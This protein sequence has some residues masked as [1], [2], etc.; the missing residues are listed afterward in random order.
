MPRASNT[1]GRA[2][3]N[4]ILTGV[5]AAA[6][7]VSFCAPA[8]AVDDDTKAEI[9]LL[10]EQLRRLEKKLEAQAQAQKETQREVATVAQAKGV[11]AGPGNLLPNTKDDGSW[12]PNTLRYK[13]VTITPGGFFE[14]VG[15]HR[16][17]YIG[18]DV[19]TPFALI[20]YSNS[21]TAHQDETRFSARRSR[22]ILQTDADLDDITHARMYLATDFLSDPQTGTFTQSQSW[23]LRWRELYTK[24]DRQDFGADYASHFSLGQMY[25]LASLNSRGTTPD[26]FLTPPVIDDQYMPGYTWARQVGVRWSQNFTKDFQVA[27]GAEQSYTSANVVPGLAFNGTIA[28]VPWN[29]VSGYALTTGV[30][31]Y[32]PGTYLQTPI[33]GSLYY[34]GNNISFSH[35]PDLITK[36]AWDPDFYGHSVHIEGG[37]MLR[38]FDDRTYGGNHGVWGGGGFASV[39]VQVIPKWLDFQASGFSGNGI[40]RYGASDQS[41]PDVAFNWTGGL[42]PIHERQVMIGLTAHPTPATDV[43]VFAGG[44]FAAPTWGDFKYPKGIPWITPN[45]YA[46]GYGNPAFVNTGCNFEGAVGGATI[47]LS[48]TAATLGPAGACVGQTKDVRQITTGMWH[49]FYDGPAGKIR[50]GLQYSYTIRDSFQGVGGAFKGTENT[51]FTSFRYYPFN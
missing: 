12:W 29:P 5:S 42:V 44:E 2:G 7:L 49:N 39:V 10:K 38:Q 25:T 4:R 26:T 36:A 17:H 20:P 11:P 40:S 48:T 16:D 21:P 27:F 24:I 9:R 32:I 30:G 3:L 37:G 50:V 22:F 28:P 19:A 47:S 1:N 8:L 18:A 41:I 13:A 35:I 14:L 46:F 31:G 51:I 43:Y 45:V 23:V 33:S 6:L 34:S 15:L